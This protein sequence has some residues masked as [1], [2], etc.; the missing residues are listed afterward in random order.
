[1]VP[2]AWCHGDSCPHGGSTQVLQPALCKE[3]SKIKFYQSS[4]TVWCTPKEKQKQAC[5]PSIPW[6][7]A[8][9]RLRAP[10]CRAAP[11]CAGWGLEPFYFSS[12]AW[13]SAER[14]LLG[15]ASCLAGA[16]LHGHPVLPC[17]LPPRLCW[18]RLENEAGLIGSCVCG[19]GVMKRFSVSLCKLP[20]ICFHS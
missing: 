16:E 19:Q 12:W 20:W 10:A 3:S 6:H 13:K 5:G 15:G 9:A 17:S 7:I 14:K 4:P 1:M 2:W 8:T 18:H 11:S